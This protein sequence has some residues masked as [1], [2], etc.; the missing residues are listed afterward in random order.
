MRKL[1]LLMRVLKA[2]R[3]P[4]LGIQ[5]NIFNKMRTYKSYV[6]RLS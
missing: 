5:V 2:K 3:C 6:F 4:I 1:L